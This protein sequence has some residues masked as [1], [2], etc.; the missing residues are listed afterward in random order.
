[1]VGLIGP[2]IDCDDEFAY[3]SGEFRSKCFAKMRL[4][5][6]ER[7]RVILFVSHDLAAIR[8]LCA[9]TILMARG[10]VIA[11]GPTEDT[12]RTYEAPLDMSANI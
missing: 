8:Q 12:I 6:S 7:G 3:G 1:M 9:R 4:D 10:T 2:H 11:D 5:A